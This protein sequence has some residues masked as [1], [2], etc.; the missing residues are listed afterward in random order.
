MKPTIKVTETK[1]PD[2]AT[3]SLV[4]HDGQFILY[5]NEREVMSTLRTHSELLLAD[6]GCKFRKARKSPRI[7]IGGLGL[8]YS[9]RRALE[10]TGPGAKV[11]VAELLPD[12]L[13]WNKEHLDGLND[14]ILADPRTE[15][16]IQD[17]YKL[18]SHAASQGP[19]FDAILL[20]VDDGPSALI[21]PQNSQ[22]YGIDG[23][24]MLKNALT[25]GGRAAIWAAGGEP[26]LM[27]AL[28]KAGF[29]TE[30]TACAKHAKARQLHHR[31]YLAEKGES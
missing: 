9:L 30:E 18:M 5:M 20:D 22:L 1:A 29:R 15:I 28:G 14:D 23:L 16:V 2:G 24:S 11:V 27:K 10:L 17:V 3:F 19:K 13:R 6:V 8:G 26:K 21:Q 31:I 25:P 4:K 7:L 12:V